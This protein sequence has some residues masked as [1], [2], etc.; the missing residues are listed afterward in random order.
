MVAIASLLASSYTMVHLL[1]IVMM[2]LLTFML[3]VLFRW[4][5]R[6]EV[7]ASNRRSGCSTEPPNGGM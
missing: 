2:S 7:A 6:R 4:F 3:R 1:N 5:S